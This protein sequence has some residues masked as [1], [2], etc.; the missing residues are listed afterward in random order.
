MLKFFGLLSLLL[1]GQLLLHSSLSLNFLCT[2]KLHLLLL[3]LK[4]LPLAFLLGF[5]GSGLTLLKLG[6]GGCLLRFE[7]L[8]FGLGGFAGLLDFHKLGS[9]LLG[10]VLCSFSAS[11]HGL[12]RGCF[13]NL[14]QSL[15]LYGSGFRLGNLFG[16]GLRFDGS[17]GQLLLPELLQR[18]LYDLL[19]NFIQF[20]LG[21]LT[22]FR[23]CFLFSCHLN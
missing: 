19:L 13:L 2:L 17:L 9:R 20:C 16:Q 3:E 21:H 23:L 10:V 11:H 18:L 7:L 22:L 4:S 1:S 12:V 8:L 14:W 15:R 6:L 5:L